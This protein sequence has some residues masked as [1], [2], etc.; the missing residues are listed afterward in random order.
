MAKDEPVKMSF[1]TAA[2]FLGAMI[3]LAT[4]PVNDESRKLYKELV[5]LSKE[6]SK[7]DPK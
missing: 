5:D 6:I 4:Q 7:G 1:L 3:L 2:S